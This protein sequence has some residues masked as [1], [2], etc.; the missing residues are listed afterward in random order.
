MDARRTTHSS[1][2]PAAGEPVADALSPAML[3]VWHA[4]PDL[5][6]AFDISA[7]RGRRGFLD[8]YGLHVAARVDRATAGRFAAWRNRGMAMARARLPA[9]LRRT[10]VAVRHVLSAARARLR[11]AAGR[12]RLRD[13]AADRPIA[14]A[15]ADRPGVR[16]VGNVGGESGMGNSLR[17]FAAACATAGVP[18]ALVD[19]R[20]R[21]PSRQVALEA[22]GATSAE[23][24][25]RSNI[26]YMPLDQVGHA[27]AALG[28]PAFTGR[29]NILVPFWELAT[30][31]DEWRH[32]AAFV[33]EIWAPTRFV[34]DA[35]A[36][37]SPRVRLVPP[38]VPE[39]RPR[40][41]DR[42]TAGLPRDAFL[43]FFSFDFFSYP[44]RKNPL[45][46]VAAFRAAFPL[47]TEPTGLIVSAMNADIRA[48]YWQ[49]LR[50]AAADDPRIRLLG[51]HR[52]HDEVLGLCQLADCY[53]SLHRAE[54]FGYGPAEAMLLGKPV[55]LTAYS[56]PLDY[57]TEENACLVGFKLVPVAAGAYPHHEGRV[58]A[59][60][61]I[62]HAAWH[63]RRLVDDPTAARRLGQAGRETIRAGFSTLLI[64]GL[65]LERLQEVGV[66]DRRDVS[67]P[68]S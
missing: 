20:L 13:R 11:V 59:E 2:E 40:Q 25:L 31:P 6:A 49:R 4:R 56:G 65:V 38:C 52:P 16:I 39:P 1:A 57:A 55:V 12:A 61:D 47:G 8:W 64:G 28:E 21:N 46:A 19:A 32:A 26:L 10:A 7:P 44:E 34:A 53:I 43:F 36:S 23:A 9:R 42:A 30:C 66:L 51:G 63:M 68:I 3:A 62:S 58:W 29:Y 17:A 37:L 35:V 54:G 14:Q 45:A 24:D 18:H 41:L 15:T 50:A 60:P 48:A 67:P 5:R 27:L 33:D 22:A